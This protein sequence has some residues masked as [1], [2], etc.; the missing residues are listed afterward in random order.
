MA[1]AVSH[2]GASPRPPGNGLAVTRTARP[3]PVVRG[4]RWWLRRYLLAEVVGAAFAITTVAVAHR[5]GASVHAEAIYGSTAE[6]VGFYAVLLVRDAA[7]RYRDRA[8]LTRAVVLTARDM[9]VEFGPAEIL[10]T[11]IVRPVLMYAGVRL[12]HDVV[13]GTV[14]GKVAADLVFYGIV[15]PCYS[16][17]MRWFPP[18]RATA[19]RPAIAAAPAPFRQSLACRAE[20]SSM[21]WPARGRASSAPVTE[22]RQNSRPFAPDSSRALTTRPSGSVSLEPDV[23]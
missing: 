21:P 15:A 11:L 1:S 19:P 4:I 12:A 13:I 16:L 2:V 20:L 9:A 23:M 14:I 6:G 5:A 18:P 10:D 8:R 7:H 22:L 17:R 3:A